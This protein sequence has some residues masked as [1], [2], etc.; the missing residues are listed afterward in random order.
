MPEGSQ[1]S[2]KSGSRSGK[3][4]TAKEFKTPITITARVKTNKN[5]IRLYFGEKGVVI[6]DW[7]YNGKELRHHDP[8][9]GE[10]SP[11][12]GKGDIPKNEFATIEWTIDAKGSHIS[13]DG[14]ERCT[15]PGDFTGLSG[16]AGIGTYDGSML[17]VKSFT[18]RGTVASP[19][20]PSKVPGP[21]V[22]A[23]GEGVAFDLPVPCAALTDKNAPATPAAPPSP[24]AIDRPEYI[25]SPKAL[26]AS[27]SSI[28]LM[29]VLESSDGDATGS[30]RDLIAIVT[31]QSRRGETAGVGFVRPQN[32]EMMRTSFEEALRAVTLRYPLWQP[33]H[34]DIS[35]RDKFTAVGGPS[36]GTAFAMLMLSIL[37]GF[38]ID[39][40]CAVTGDISVDWKTEKV[41]GIAFKLR[42]AVLDKRTLAIIPADNAGALS[43]M[44][45]QQG[46][47]G[48]Y[49]VQVF[50]ASTLQQAIAVARQD[51]SS[52]LKE[53]ITS[54]TA[55]QALLH[56][57]EGAALRNPE[58]AK[59][60]SRILEL[61]PNHASARYLL[62][63]IEGKTLKTLSLGA[64]L[65]EV[66]RV[67]YPYRELLTIDNK[68]V[69]VRV[70]QELRVTSR[71]R[72]DAIRP[73]IHKDFAP[74]V[75]D[76]GAFMEIA[77]HVSDK[78]SPVS[79]LRP[80]L[81]T[82]LKDLDKVTTDQ[83]FIEQALRDGN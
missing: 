2:T 39:P 79:A 3:L 78:Q 74:I 52:D 56:K 80:P 69:G 37:E 5:N 55:L 33:G 82:L 27:V 8:R 83:N 75:R 38:K 70:P 34:I 16:K 49:N 54:F 58:T 6:F 45:I 15:M 31:P 40:G 60:L 42:G 12:A 77:D 9:S 29:T 76:I 73:I 14:V 46:L 17:T 67:L 63:S 41:G 22:A 23:V 50:T 61:A 81:A 25:N 11:L 35:F 19:A 48:V 64:S 36:A 59:T 21:A 72:L 62:D 1:I 4:L 7:E 57:S 28:S 32:D 51:R 43:D 26:V 30:V 20:A 71:R 44:V 68:T 10:E 65:Y 13:V 53:A 47:S 66:A 18:V 24:D